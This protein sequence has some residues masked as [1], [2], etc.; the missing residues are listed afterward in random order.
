MS[1]NSKDP[2]IRNENPGQSASRETSSP[3]ATSPGG[4]PGGSPAASQAF[5]KE[6]QKES[7]E[8]RERLQ[9]SSAGPPSSPVKTDMLDIGKS[10]LRG[11]QRV[12][13]DAQQIM[14]TSPLGKVLAGHTGQSSP[15]RNSLSVIPSGPGSH[16]NSL[17]IVPPQSPAGISLH[18]PSSA[19]FSKAL[20]TP[21]LDRSSDS[22]GSP[23]DDKPIRKLSLDLPSAR[24]FSFIETDQMRMAKKDK[25][26]ERP[27]G[28]QSIS[29]SRSQIMQSGQIAITQRKIP[30][31]EIAGI[32]LI[33]HVQERIS[34]EILS[35]KRFFE[36]LS[37][38]RQLALSLD[39]RYKLDG[40]VLKLTADQH[41][42]DS[43]IL[44]REL[45]DKK[46]RKEFSESAKHPVLRKAEILRQYLLKYYSMNSEISLVNFEILKEVIIL[47]LKLVKNQLA[48]QDRTHPSLQCLKYI[49]SELQ[50]VRQIK[51]V[52]YGFSEQC[53]IFLQK[54]IREYNKA[55]EELIACFRSDI[56]AND[57]DKRQKIQAKIYKYSCEKVKEFCEQ[58][59]IPSFKAYEKLNDYKS[60]PESYQKA[61]EK[62]KGEI[63]YRNRKVYFKNREDLPEC[64]ALRLRDFDA[65][66]FIKMKQE[67]LKAQ[68]Q[69]LF[70][71]TQS[72]RPG[73]PSL[74][75]SNV[76]FDFEAIKYRTFAHVDKD[77]KRPI[78]CLPSTLFKIDPVFLELET[79]A[80][81]LIKGLY[82]LKET[83][84]HF[85]L[86]FRAETD[87]EFLKI[88]HCSLR[89]QYN[90]KDDPYVSI[91][92]LI[93]GGRYANPEDVAI[94]RYFP[95]KE[96]IQYS[97]PSLASFG[98]PDA[99]IPLSVS[100]VKVETITTFQ[101]IPD[102]EYAKYN[103]PI[104]ESEPFKERFPPI[105]PYKSLFQDSVE[106]A[107][108][109]Q[110][111]NLES[112][113]LNAS[114]CLQ[115]YL[116]EAWIKYCQSLF[117]SCGSQESHPIK[118][119]LQSL[120]SIGYFD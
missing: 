87:K 85:M 109:L 16:R 26:L 43:E 92:D 34:Y 39:E 118:L 108:Q 11:V 35:E 100:H 30:R 111:E 65:A 98:M 76:P 27:S 112:L 97:H 102:A 56:E 105:Q 48:E 36:Y 8:R 74:L 95:Y 66:L 40:V 84:L 29:S 72:I 91:F 99:E 10:M 15:H 120:D 7:P 42:L 83:H 14:R 117:W 58:K 53:A 80:F 54:I 113:K 5:S 38:L 116:K 64:R 94:V 12:V 50:Q 71:L 31:G 101:P 60:L 89:L 4:S 3:A 103:R 37:K 19:G 93:Y 46:N 25:G 73:V 59:Q 18:S 69:D 44:I 32:A 67:K 20:G 82:D 49:D 86:F 90:Y 96:S 119:K 47:M 81:A 1:V 115:Q 23:A 88:F 9:T 68:L 6:Q 114:Q 24:N 75:F 13:G 107:N 51:E 22:L 21:G 70:N 79:R 77:S 61:R 17:S 45:G 63:S 28:R 104:E 57:N 33:A 78:L 62:S 55:F 41:R 106:I 52:I 110:I 2:A